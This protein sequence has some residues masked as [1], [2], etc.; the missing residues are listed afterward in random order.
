M[1]ILWHGVAPW[2]PT[3][4]GQQAAIWSQRLKDAGH[5]VAIAAQGGNDSCQI[6]QWNGIPV[7]PQAKD[8]QA[9]PLVTTQ[10]MAQ[11]RP[12]LVI[13]CYDPWQM[14]EGEIFRPYQTV[15]WCP[16]DTDV[17]TIGGKPQGLG[18]SIGDLQWLEQSKA[19]PLAMSRHG[20]KML[21]HAGY[22]ADLIPHGIDTQQAFTPLD[23]GRREKLRGQLGIHPDTFA[24]GIMGM[25]ND[26]YRKSFQE[27]LPAFARFH[28][29]H[30]EAQLHIHSQLYLPGS[31]HL[32]QLAASLGLDGEACKVSHQ[33]SIFTGMVSQ[34]DMARW[35]GCMDVVLNCARA[36]GFGLAAVEAQAC[37]TPV[38]LS[39]HHTGPELV[40]PGW[41]VSGQEFWNERHQGVW[42]TPSIHGIFNALCKA[43]TDAAGKR[44]DARAF[45][46]QFDVDAVWPL[47]EKFLAGL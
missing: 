27:Q 47:W 10:W 7:F 14:G 20:Q 18:I 25:N 43:R 37:G 45:A 11:Y 15:A 30:P 9:I 33:G 2:Q 29:K 42:W 4:Y 46:E 35:Y 44:D 39:G 23:P 28:A 36:E 19:T 8:T 31:V 1:R 22:E 34:G 17:W 40:G 6:V 16:I 26:R 32:G 38:V 3:G 12:D 13:I 24:V 21:K 5:E 41:L